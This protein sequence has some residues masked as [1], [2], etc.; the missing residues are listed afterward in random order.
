MRSSLHAVL[1]PLLLLATGNTTECRL[2]TESG[3]GELQISG[4]VHFLE[5]D[6][7]CW[8]LETEAGR[9]YEL[10]PGQV[11]DSMLR[12]G[13][14]VSVVGQLVEGSETGCQ[15]GIALHVRR[16]VTME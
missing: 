13:A 16:V 4:T 6:G 8:Q 1:L 3:T 5:V 7:G 15:V 2:S 12:D 10:V 9:R 11:P 14:R